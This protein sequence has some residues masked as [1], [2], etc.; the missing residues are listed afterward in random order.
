MKVGYMGGMRNILAL[1]VLLSAP[2]ALG[3]VGWGLILIL[4]ATSLPVFLACCAV[5]I[6]TGLGMASLLDSRQ[7]L[8]SQ[9]QHDQ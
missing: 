1:W 4:K 7:P 3:V 5:M 9:R 8:Q 6:T 2:A